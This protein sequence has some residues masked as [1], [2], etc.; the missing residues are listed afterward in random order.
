MS[1]IAVLHFQ[2]S[3]HYLKYTNYTHKNSTPLDSVDKSLLVLY[4]NTAINLYALSSE[5]ASTSAILRACTRFFSIIVLQ[6]ILD[7][8]LLY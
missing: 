5:P 3:L 2:E 4:S 8:L 6:T 1:I 7:Y